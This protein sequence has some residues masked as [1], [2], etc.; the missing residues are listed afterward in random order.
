MPTANPSPANDSLGD[1]ALRRALADFVRRRVPS[2]EVD[3]V[4]Q[5]VLVEALAAPNRPR[6]PTELKRWLLGIAR[7]KVVDFHRRSMREPPSELADIEASPA[8]LEAR[9]LARWAEEQAGSTGDAQKTLDWMAR[10]GEGE[11]LEAIAAEEQVPAARVR[12][13]VSR[14]RRWMKE[15]W[16]AE[17]AAVAMLGLLALAAWWLLRREAPTTDKGPEVPPTIAPEPPS[18]IERGRLLRADALKACDRGEWRLCLDGLEQAK[19]LDPEGDRAPAV[20]AAR[21]KAE[22][23]LRAAPPSTAPA[24]KEGPPTKGYEPP[25]PSDGGG[26]PSDSK[27]AP[28]FEKKARPKPA[29]PVPTGTPTGG[30]GD[31][32]L[33]EPSPKKP[34]TG[35][36]TPAPKPRKGSKAMMKV[37]DSESY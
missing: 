10:E 29:P 6:D 28:S 5:T 20:G 2:A 13:R 31:F 8:P 11:K 36:G 18:P 25:S 30:K 21:Q 24:P 4:V 14:M 26:L 37:I 9:A 19:G 15:R 35:T 22:D 17:L 16:M 7:H 33:D 1:P 12:Q 27:E 3:D 32:G 34:G 23:A